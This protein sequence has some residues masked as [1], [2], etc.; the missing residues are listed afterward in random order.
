MNILLIDDMIWDSFLPSVLTLFASLGIDASLPPHAHPLG[1]EWANDK[2]RDATVTVARGGAPDVMKAA[3]ILL[4][5]LRKG[6]LGRV[7]LETV[8]E[9]AARCRAEPGDLCAAMRMALPAC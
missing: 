1:Y 4:H 7:T 5:E 6:L 3:G 8:A 2:D 9:V